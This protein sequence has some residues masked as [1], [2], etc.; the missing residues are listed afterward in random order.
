MT[1]GGRVIGEHHSSV[2]T[3]VAQLQGNQVAFINFQLI[4]STYGVPYLPLHTLS[5]LKSN[6]RTLLT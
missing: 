1:M 2:D 4:R 6:V 3:I 5:G